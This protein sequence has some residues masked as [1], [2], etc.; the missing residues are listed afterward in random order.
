MEATATQAMA[1]VDITL[2]EMEAALLV[3]DVAGCEKAAQRTRGLAAQV[4]GPGMCRIAVPI[5]ES[6]ERLAQLRARATARGPRV[7]TTTARRL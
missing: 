6:G 2:R 4:T 5:V 3:K 7:H 1:S